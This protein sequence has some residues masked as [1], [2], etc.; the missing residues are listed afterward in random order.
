MS[1]TISPSKRAV[2]RLLP[3]QPV[4]DADTHITE[5]YDLW[6]SRAPAKFRDRVPQV[7]D[8]NG[9]WEW[10]FDGKSMG[11]NGA[12]SCISKTGEKILGMDF[13]KMQLADVFLGSYDVKERVKFMDSEGIAA[14]IGYPN[15]MGFGGQA[16]MKA[17]KELRDACVIIFNDAMAE[18][19]ADSGNRI[20]PM[21]MMPWWDIDFCVREVERCA[22]MGFRGINMNSDPN[23]HGFPT[24]G[25]EAWTPLWE[26]C[27]DKA[28]PVNF[29]I[30]ASDE[31]M[32]WFGHGLW[33]EFGPNIKLA[34]GSL[35]LFFGNMRVLANIL[36]SG[37]LEKHPK[38][39][40]VSVESGAGWIPFFL[41][42]IE[43]QM[44][45]AGLKMD[46]TPREVFQRQIYVC[47][48]F[49][50]RDLVHSARSIGVDNLMYETDFPHPT[51]L[52]PDSQEYIVE[53]MEAFTPEER[54]KV[55]GGT[56]QRL[57][58][59][60]LSAWRKTLA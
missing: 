57:Y 46:M 27:I 42:G 23:D 49:E 18:L 6:T 35:T 55:Y 1:E 51:C 38:L 41:E 28:F 5:W 21:A 43:Y 58:N 2:D 34:Y 8:E 39:N 54:R 40:I 31:T 22:A 4:V 48:W 19:Q 33:P 24:L 10:M 7:V 17:D 59:L 44:R 3:G 20:Y 52:Y 50:R 14:Q 32:S 30:G 37:F 15:L 29:H 45:E 60:D 13:Q 11:R 53:A 47:S 16:S 56:A 9:K 26:A 12:S 36:F 25:N